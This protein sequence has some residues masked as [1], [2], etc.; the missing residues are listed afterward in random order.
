[1]SFRIEDLDK[2]NMKKLVIE[3]SAEKFDEALDKAYQKN[4]NKI[5]IQGFRKGKAPKALIEKMYGPSVFYE[6]AANILIP[7][8]YEA[9]AEECGL[10]IVSRPEIDVE[11]I[12]KGKSFIFTAEVAVKPEVKLGSYKGVE[13]EKADITVTDDEVKAELDKAVEQSSRLVK[14]TDRAVEDGD[15]AT[16]DF[17]G[18]MDGKAFAGGKGENHELTIG[19]HSFIDTFEEQLIGKN[20]GDECEVNVTFPAEYHAAELAGKPAMF[21]VTVKGIQKKELPELNDEFAKDTTEFETLDEYKADIK[22][23][24]EEKKA[25][26]A[27]E[28]KRDD[29][30]AKIVEASEMS[31]PEPMLDLQKRRMVEDFEQRLRYQG[32]KLEQYM[33]FTG[34]TPDKF[35][36]QMEPA[37]KKEIEQRLVLEAIV[38]A[39]NIEVSEEELEAEFKSMADQ[40]GMDLENVKKIIGDKEKDNVKMDLAVRKAADLVTD[41]AVEK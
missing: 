19:S 9:A 15:I 25:R 10:D 21:K 14:V 38:K 26:E 18:F 5:S 40:Y 4:K 34:L 20:I 3:V 13:V 2:E 12:E 33:Q 39:E 30:V 28:K 17:E 6:D 36:E 29:V 41:A 1:M 27:K 7:D 23:K 24:L 16:I 35:L 37:A 8:E 11:Q 22:K 32:L 31:I